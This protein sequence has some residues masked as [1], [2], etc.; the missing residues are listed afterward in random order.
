VENS[1]VVGGLVGDLLTMT[2]GAFNPDNYWRDVLAGETTLF[3]SDSATFRGTGDFVNVTGTLTGAND[4]FEGKETAISTQSFFGD[5]N[6]VLDSSVLTGGDDTIYMREIGLIAGDAWGAYGRLNGGDDTIVIDGPAIND[7]VARVSGDLVFVTDL[8]PE[9]TFKPLVFGGNDTITVLNYA[10][11]AIRNH[12]T[13]PLH[14]A[15]GPSAAT[16]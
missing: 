6:F 16:T 9:F 11:G 14:R 5:A 3:A 10:G 8:G 4:L 15:A 7:G 1:Y 13:A 12:W 2:A